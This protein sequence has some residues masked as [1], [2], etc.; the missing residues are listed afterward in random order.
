MN[1]GIVTANLTDMVLEYNML[2]NP[3]KKR[4]NSMI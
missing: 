1:Y 3:N 2:S 4:K